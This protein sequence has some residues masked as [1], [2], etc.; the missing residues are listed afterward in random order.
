MGAGRTYGALECTGDDAMDSGDDI[1]G[2]GVTG[3]MSRI[4]GEHLQLDWGHIGGRR[5]VTLVPHKRGAFTTRL[6]NRG[7]RGWTETVGA[8]SPR[9]PGH[10]RK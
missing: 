3:H 10:Y 9:G 6:G 7:K 8:A 5:N 1:W 4:S 2:E